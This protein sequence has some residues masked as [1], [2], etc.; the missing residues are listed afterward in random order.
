MNYFFL[1]SYNTYTFVYKPY[2]LHSNSKLLWFTLQLMRRK[3]NKKKLNR[4]NN[5]FIMHAIICT[6]TGVYGKGICMY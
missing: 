1:L 6:T 4:G 2:T 3:Q 5:N